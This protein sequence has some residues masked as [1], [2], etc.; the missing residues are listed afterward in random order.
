MAKHQPALRP[1]I[2]KQVNDGKIGEK[3]V[4]EAKDL[5]IRNRMERRVGV[6]GQFRADAL[7]EIVYRF[8]AGQSEGLGVEIRTVVHADIGMVLKEVEDKMLQGFV[9]IDEKAV[10]PVEDRKEIVGVVFKE[11]T[12]VVGRDDGLPVLV[13]PFAVLADADVA[14]TGL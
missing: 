7:A 9:E 13:A 12:A 4:A 10:V 14:H 2:E 8:L 3:T 6:V 11:C 5:E 1:H